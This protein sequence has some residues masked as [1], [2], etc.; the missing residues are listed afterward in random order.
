[1]ARAHLNALRAWPAGLLHID[2]KQVALRVDPDGLSFELARLNA[3][4]RQQGLI[5]A[6]PRLEDYAVELR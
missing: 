5:K 6:E 1:M 2:D 3:A 4:L